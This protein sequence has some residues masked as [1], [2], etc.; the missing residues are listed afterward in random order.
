WVLAYTSA[1]ALLGLGASEVLV[2]RYGAVGAAFA[3]FVSILCGTVVLFGAVARRLLQLSVR[4]VAFALALPVAA[5]VIVAAFYAVGAVMSTSL[6]AAL[7][8]GALVT[9]AYAGG[10]LLLILKRRER[11]ALPSI[12]VE[13]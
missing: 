7:V 6:P 1:V 5:V 4:D 12:S 13:A 3:L 9:A 11:H 10:A 8:T 2:P